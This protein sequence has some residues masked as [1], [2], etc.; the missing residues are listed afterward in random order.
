MILNG[1]ALFVEPRG[2]R[3]VVV[4]LLWH[5]RKSECAVRRRFQE[6]F[7]FNV[8]VG[9]LAQSIRVPVFGARAMDN[10]E[11]VLVESR[12]PATNHCHI[13]KVGLEPGQGL[14]FYSQ[15]EL[16]RSEIRMEFVDKEVDCEHFKFRGAILHLCL[17]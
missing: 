9:A 8:V 3:Q 1:L 6:L 16:S 7:S 12:N 17:S 4:C 15:S 5:K 2:N 14:V 11:M 10:F 13:R